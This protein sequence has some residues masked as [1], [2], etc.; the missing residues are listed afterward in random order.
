MFSW[1]EE[2]SLCD[3][4]TSNR[5]RVIFIL[6]RP[7]R[8]R[9]EQ[10]PEVAMIGLPCEDGDVSLCGNFPS[11]SDAKAGNIE[12]S[13]CLPYDEF[14]QGRVRRCSFFHHCLFGEQQ[15]SSLLLGSS[16]AR[17]AEPKRCLLWL[18]LSLLMVA[19]PNPSIYRKQG[20]CICQRG[21]P[22]EVLVS[23]LP[24]CSSE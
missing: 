21:E 8:G 15:R 1:T 22:R 11:M 17:P 13:D 5:V 10:L 20:V 23:K 16:Y 2:M 18:L 6:A 14:Q 19:K 9:E 12:E 24:S 4:K 3:P 7:Y